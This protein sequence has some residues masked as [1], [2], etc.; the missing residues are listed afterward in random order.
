MATKG[1]CDVLRRHLLDNDGLNT[2]LGGYV[3]NVGLYVLVRHD[4]FQKNMYWYWAKGFL[5]GGEDVDCVLEQVA[6]RTR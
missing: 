3:G 4:I 6:R 2:Q 1:A 5:D